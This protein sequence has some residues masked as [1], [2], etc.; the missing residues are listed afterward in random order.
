MSIHRHTPTGV[1]TMNL[2]QYKKVVNFAQKHFLSLFSVD[3]KNNNI[4]SLEEYFGAFSFLCWANKSAHRGSIQLN[5]ENDLPDGDSLLYTIKKG[6]QKNYHDMFIAITD[7]LLKLCESFRVF[8]KVNGF[9]IAIDY[10]DRPYHGDKNDEGIVGSKQKPHWAYRF[11]TVDIIERGN[12][13]TLFMLPYKEFD[14]DEKIVRKLLEETKKRIKIKC[15][16]G[17][18]EFSYACLIDI[19]DELN[20]D[21]IIRAKGNYIYKKEN[22]TNKPIW[23]KYTRK[24]YLNKNPIYTTT[25]WVICVFRNKKRETKKESY[26]TNKTVT[27]S[28]K[29]KFYKW[30]DQRWGIEIDYRSNNV[31]MPKTSAKKYIVRFFYFVVCSILR[32][33]WV[34]INLKIKVRCNMKIRSKPVLT[35]DDFVFLVFKL[36][37]ISV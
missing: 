20:I 31:F 22:K 7:K 28:N 33:V 36:Y 24:R 21:Y 16:Y 1:W 26:F 5:L 14:T 11:A 18:Q 30:Y 15:L 27:H 9:D 34:F 12:A 17:D 25:I 4:Y 13:I 29:N 35:A 32:N 2:K 19:Y 10:H 3:I 23:F 8:Q 37:N 6:N